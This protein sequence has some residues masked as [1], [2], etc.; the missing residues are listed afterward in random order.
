MNCAVKYEVYQLR[1]QQRRSLLSEIECCALT[2]L[3]TV[4]DT[5]A[6]HQVQFFPINHTQ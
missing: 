2:L 6:T 3:L 5:D 1:S 4:T